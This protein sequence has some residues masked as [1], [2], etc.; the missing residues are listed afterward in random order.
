MVAIVAFIWP[1]SVI[2]QEDIRDWK[3]GEFKQTLKLI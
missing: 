2:A 3:T 1:F